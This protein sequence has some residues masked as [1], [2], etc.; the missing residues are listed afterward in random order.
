MLFHPGAYGEHV[1]IKNNILRRKPDF[2]HEQIVSAF[3]DLGAS[4]KRIGLA[5]FI[6]RQR[7]YDRRAV[8]ARTR[9]A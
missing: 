7:Y 6:E 2:L 5:S 8:E 1:G 9:F 3:A 4:L